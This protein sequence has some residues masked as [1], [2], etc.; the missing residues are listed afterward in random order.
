VSFLVCFFFFCFSLRSATFLAVPVGRF[1]SFVSI[2][3][4]RSFSTMI[5][6][7]FFS[8][9][10][11]S[12]APRL[13]RRRYFWPSTRTCWFWIIVSYWPIRLSSLFTIPSFPASILHA[14]YLT[15]NRRLLCSSYLFFSFQCKYVQKGN[16]LQNERSLLSSRR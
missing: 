14:L 15:S 6:L 5:F 16:F 8:C 2:Q 7:S 10:L 9:L 13:R 11:P 3:Y 12:S 1:C 4:R